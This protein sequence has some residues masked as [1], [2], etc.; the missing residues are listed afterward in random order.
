MRTPTSGPFIIALVAALAATAMFA[1]TSVTV[2]DGDTLSSIARRHGVSTAELVAWNDIDDPDR[3]FVGEVIFLT[4]PP[5][6]DATGVAS[7]VVSAGDT[8]TLIAAR[9][10]ASVGAIAEANGLS[11]VDFIRVGQQLT[12]GAAAADGGTV[13]GSGI[14]DAGSA[15]GSDGDDTEHTVAAG[16]TLFSIANRY[17][18]T[19]TALAVAN[20]ITDADRIRIGDVLVI[21]PANAA[22]DSEPE[23]E[24]TEPPA[25]ETPADT[26][27]DDDDAASE[28]ADEPDPAPTDTTT[29]E[30]DPAPAAPDTRT[31]D[32][33]VL[34]DPDASA[35]EL[36]EAFALWSVSYGVDQGLLEAIAWYATDWQPNTVGID[37]RVGIAQLTPAQVELVE[38]RLLGR[39]LDPLDGPDGV[40]LAAR[41]LRFVQ[42][43][44]GTETDALRAFRQGL[45]SLEDD[46]PTADAEAFALAVLNIRDQRS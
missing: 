15:A 41:Y 25:D 37:N 33:S 43:R 46:G 5:D 14:S 1:T 10:G 13:S 22:S 38:T 29:D 39:D 7:H 3:I 20:D 42:D 18:R 34:P 24:P 9:Y 12:I 11:D 26:T 45:D 6:T 30:P 27:P 32:V 17:E 28:P 8:L 2:T 23:P 19:V 35:A 40:R 44:T 31:D 16:E 21:P 4:A 36:S